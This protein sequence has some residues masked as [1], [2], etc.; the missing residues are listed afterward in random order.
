MNHFK[1]ITPELT[2]V[3]IKKMGG[4]HVMIKSKM[5]TKLI[6]LEIRPGMPQRRKC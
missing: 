3:T 6:L 4:I 1:T 5:S 2:V